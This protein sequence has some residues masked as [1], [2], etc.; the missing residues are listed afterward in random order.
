MCA[1]DLCVV[2]GVDVPAASPGGHEAAGTH[3]ALVGGKSEIEACLAALQVTKQTSIHLNQE[4]LLPKTANRA[5][6]QEK[7][8]KYIFSYLDDHSMIW[9]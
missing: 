8:S 7:F 2:V 4:Y 1:T 5:F 3:S 9:V 6:S